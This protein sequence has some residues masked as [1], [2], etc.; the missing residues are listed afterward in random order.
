VS[1]FSYAD[2]SLNEAQTVSILPQ[3]FTGNS[4]AATLQV[5]PS[6]RFLYASNRGADNIAV[7]SIDPNTGTLTLVE[8]VPTEGKTPG[9]FGIDP[10]GS[11]LIVANQ[12]SDSLV[13][14]SIDPQTG[15]PHA[16]G[17]T[18]QIGTPSCVRFLPL[19]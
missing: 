1:T 13:Q 9:N 18:F 3:G 14:F 16:T 6:G 8:F 17:Q 19:H 7:Y 10:S 11:W 2:G 5:H 4:T 15:R 12:S